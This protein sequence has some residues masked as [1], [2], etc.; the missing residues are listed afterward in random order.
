TT[1]LTL[2]TDRLRRS[3]RLPTGPALRQA[4]TLLAD[5]MKLGV[6]GLSGKFDTNMVGGYFED[7]EEANDWAKHFYGT[8]AEELSP[9]EYSALDEYKREGFRSL[10]RGLR[11]HGGE[12]SMLSAE[13]RLRAEG[14]DAALEKAPPLE[15][16]MVVYRGRL[17]D[18]VLEAFET[19]EEETLVGQVFG[20]PA[21]T[22]TSLG[23]TTARE[24]GSSSRFPDSV[25]RITLPRGT[26]AGYVDTVFDKGQSELLLSR[27]ARVRIDDAFREGGVYRIEG[28]LVAP[29]DAHNLGGRVGRE[30]RRRVAGRPFRSAGG[31]QAPLPRW[32]RRQERQGRVAKARQAQGR[33]AS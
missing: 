2:D 12:I 19:G 15:R 16:P 8:W 6:Q 21:Y 13:D 33:E 18:A 27:E 4:A 20:D 26:K 23:I 30:T 7:L 14:L 1:A 24:Y 32:G 17:P 11:D 31:R 10:N 5:L 25:G 3:S 9:E 28:Q 29:A 22:S